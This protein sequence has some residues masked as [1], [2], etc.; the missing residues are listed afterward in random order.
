MN[1]RCRAF[2]D[3]EGRFHGYYITDP[4]PPAGAVSWRYRTTYEVDFK[5]YGLPFT[6]KTKPILEGTFGPAPFLGLKVTVA[7]HLRA[8][9]GALAPKLASGRYVLELTVKSDVIRGAFR[10]LFFTVKGK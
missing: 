10:A 4:L 9:I 5:L 2:V 7:L 8:V 6:Y 3:E 1:F